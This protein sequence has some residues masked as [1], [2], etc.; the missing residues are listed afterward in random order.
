[1]D[2][3]EGRGDRQHHRDGADRERAGHRQRQASQEAT[4]ADQP[5]RGQPGSRGL[6]R[7]GMRD[8]L[9]RLR[10][11][12]R[13]MELRLGHVRLV[14]LPGRLL[15]HGLDPPSLLHQRGQV[16]RDRQAAGVSGDH[17]EDYRH[18]H[19]GQRVA[20]PGT[21]QLHTHLPGVVHHRRTLGVP[22]E[23]PS[24]RE[25]T[26]D[27]LLFGGTGRCALEGLVGFLLGVGGCCGSRC[28]R[29][30]CRLRFRMCDFFILVL[31]AAA[32]LALKEKR[33]IAHSATCTSVH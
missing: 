15:L 1:M 7:G 26:V 6:P 5:L 28:N 22:Q 10:G 25:Q 11:A 19:A 18:L 9:Q 20:A 32:R 4:G 8:E 29:Q 2:G 14:E 30:T 27:E 24:G 16:L 21:H 3:G 31:L 33:L 17:E 23:E 13:P 12:D